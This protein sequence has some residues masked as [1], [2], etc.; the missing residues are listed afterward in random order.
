MS[1]MGYYFDQTRCTGCYACAVACKDWHDIDA[2]PV[3]WMQVKVIENGRFPTPF[4]AYLASP[5]YQC[6]NPPCV[7]ACPADAIVKRESD[8]IVVVNRDKCLGKKECHT[9]CLNACPWDAPQFG[10]EENATMQKCD[11]CLDRLEQGQKPICIEACPMYALD[12][13][14]MDELKAEYGEDA[15]A[16]G[17]SYSKR[18]KPAVVFKQKRRTSANI[19]QS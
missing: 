11:F 14:P 1:Q 17:F 5:C 19:P 4:L 12:I 2:G 16:E 3:N 15:M 7:L 6:V 9:L 10:P 8:G 13:G 18:F